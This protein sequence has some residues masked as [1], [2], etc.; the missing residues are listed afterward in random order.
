MLTDG[1]LGGSWGEWHHPLLWVIL[2]NKSAVPDVGKAVHIKQ[3][4]M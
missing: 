1:Y 2:D 4:E 3:R